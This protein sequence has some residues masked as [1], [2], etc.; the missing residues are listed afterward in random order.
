[1]K[2]MLTY[3]AKNTNWKLCGFFHHL[4]NAEIYEQYLKF[5]NPGI[6]TDI[7]PVNIDPIRPLPD[8]DWDF[9]EY[10]K[11]CEENGVEY[12]D[13]VPSPEYHVYRGECNE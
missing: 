13:F 5:H 7:E 8:I 3:K 1:M 4:E 12:I 11:E 2:Y 10:Y 6:D 9:N